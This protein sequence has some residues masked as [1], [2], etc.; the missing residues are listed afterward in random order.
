MQPSKNTLVSLSDY[1]RLVAACRDFAVLAVLLVLVFVLI[2]IW[3]L[4][5]EARP[6]VIA[7]LD[8]AQNA[9]IHSEA[10]AQKVSASMGAVQRSAEAQARLFEDPEVQ[11]SFGLLGRQGDDVARVLDGI[12]ALQ[13]HLKTQSLPKFDQ[14]LDRSDGLLETAIGTVGESKE[15]VSDL[16]KMIGSPEVRNVLISTNGT[17]VEAQE[18]LTETRITL[19]EFNQELPGLMRALQSAGVG[20]GKLT[21][22]GAQLLN[23]IN[24]PQ[25]RKEKVWR[26]LVYTVGLGLPAALR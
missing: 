5:I 21:D 6:R 25:T 3:A 15:L 12:Q 17:L 2:E 10:A 24:R 4:I 16:R 18:L 8:H 22:E 9:A 20:T 14:L 19:Q 23:R 7:T 26:V 11:R 13:R 1:G